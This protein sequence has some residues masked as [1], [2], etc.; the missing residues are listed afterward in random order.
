MDLLQFPATEEAYNKLSTT[1]SRNNPLRPRE[2]NH[3]AYTLITNTKCTAL[4]F[5][6]RAFMDYM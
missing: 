6:N 2:N 1:Q 4:K 3:V 5:Q